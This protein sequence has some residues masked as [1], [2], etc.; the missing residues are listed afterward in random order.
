ML[1]KPSIHT[2]LKEAV[3]NHFVMEQVVMD[4]TEKMKITAWFKHNEPIIM[5]KMN[6]TQITYFMREDSP[7]CH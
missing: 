3:C 2:H 4:K 1:S 7:R 5:L 6:H